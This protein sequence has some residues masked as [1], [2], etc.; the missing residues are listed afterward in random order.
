MY[1]LNFWLIDKKYLEFNYKSDEYKKMCTVIEVYKNEIN[2]DITNEDI[3]F[4]KI[5][6]SNLDT[7]IKSKIN[8]YL[9][10]IFNK[11]P[12]NSLL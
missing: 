12:N 10:E 1:V 8:N 5:N 6:I 3:V 7:E 2:I 9:L 11:L 4:G